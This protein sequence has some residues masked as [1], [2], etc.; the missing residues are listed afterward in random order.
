MNQYFKGHLSH[1]MFLALTA[2]GI[3]YGDIGTSPLYALRECFW[4][5]HAV[6]LNNANILGIL[7]LIFWSLVFVISVKYLVIVCKADNRGEGG[8]L[9]LL[10]LLVDPS[11]KFTFSPWKKK[12]IIWMGIFGAALLYGDGMLTP[13]ISIIGALEG[14]KVA[15]ASFDNYVVPLAATIIF[16][17]FYL[18]HFGTHR[19]GS[20]FGPVMGVWFSTLA[21]SGVYW[22]VKEPT[23]LFALNPWYAFSF[24]WFNPGYGFVV[25][26]AIF[27]VVTGG[28]ALYADMGHFG[29][30]P[31][32]L[33][34]FGFVFPSL[35]IHYMGQGALLIQ[36]PLAIENPFFNMVPESLLY[37]LIG[38]SVMAS[39]IASQ[40]I[41]SGV[42]SL[43]QQAIHLGYLPRMKV[44]HTSKSERGQ[45][46]LP[47]ANWLLFLAT[48]WI[49]FEFQS[50]TNLAGAYG[51]AVATTMVITTLLL[52]F[53]ASRKWKWSLFSIAI[54]LIPFFA[55]DMV[56]LVSN[57][58]K[59]VAGG[60]VP[61][62]VAL[63][64]FILMT[65]W[66]R[67]Q[68][69]LRNT[70]EYEIPAL[71]DFLQDLKE[72]PVSRIPGLAVYMSRSV[73][74][75]PPALMTNLEH[76]KVV[77]DEIIIVTIINL[78]I[79]YVGEQEKHFVQ[80]LGNGFYRVVIKY[81]FMERPSVWTELN[82]VKL[83]ELTHPLAD[84]TF[85]L[86]H[87]TVVKTDTKTRFTW[88]E[89]L[90]EWMYR[91]AQ[92]AYTYFE[93]PPNQV[94]EVGSKMVI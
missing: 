46:Y 92:G 56:F 28:E 55:I 94:M 77:H 37:P 86:G 64:I 57:M 4:G 52:Y 82:K 2:L 71:E 3:V 5:P 16:G 81:G 39:I 1:K 88:R 40:A 20:L 83:E 11:E 15:T 74:S 29:A 19:V 33:A 34:W 89:K 66:K 84:A 18:Q 45:I 38:L 72:H 41:I 43:T 17:L 75:T 44:L 67:G 30:G 79:P 35:I 65:T 47:T 32:K 10:A 13:A 73:F 25:L 63:F 27:L 87:Q 7:S 50:S 23:V 69:L 26:G 61:L 85:F 14:L 12:A 48:I 80:S 21:I 68:D 60:W 90:F 6:P 53:V 22:I 70:L 78:E 51:I 62:S 91:N 31:I 93:I 76:L 54:I 59:I 49:V 9:A 24:A 8:I 36:N 58:L 42:F